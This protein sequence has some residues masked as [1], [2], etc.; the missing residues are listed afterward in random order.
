VAALGTALARSDMNADTSLNPFD[1]INATA[2]P[3]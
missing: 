2:P 1:E 3:Q